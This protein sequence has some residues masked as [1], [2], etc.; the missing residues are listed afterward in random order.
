MRLT[1]TRM[2]C[3]RILDVQLLRPA[4]DTTTTEAAV[5]ERLSYWGS[6]V[7]HIIARGIMSTVSVR[8]D[9]KHVRRVKYVEVRIRRRH[10]SN[11]QSVV[12]L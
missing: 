7:Q 1:K 3:D 6:P 11:T 12:L 8:V 5:S 10:Y 2:K 4:N 9:L